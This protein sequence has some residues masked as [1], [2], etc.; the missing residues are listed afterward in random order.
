MRYC[1]TCGKELTD[2][3]R[4]CSGCGKSVSSE[5]HDVE[6]S[7]GAIYHLPITEKRKC[8]IKVF[9]DKVVFDGSFWFLKDKDFYHNKTR[10]EIANPKDFIGIGY[11]KKR[12]YRKGIIFVFAGTILE[13]IKFV[14]DKLNSLVGKANKYLDWL[15]MSIELPVWLEYV[16]NGA[17]IVCLFLAIRYFFSKKKVIEVSFINKRICI[18]EKS[19][20]SQEFV[21]LRES[22]LKCK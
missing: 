6:N 1:T 20:T 7:I 14:I 19:L 13:G 12:S 2:D 18:P 4:F 15:D 22:I 8:D 11:L 16:M 9:S 5:P 17:T 3:M 10:T 21:N